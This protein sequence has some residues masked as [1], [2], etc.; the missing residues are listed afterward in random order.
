MNRRIGGNG[1]SNAFVTMERHARVDESD[2]GDLKLMSLVDNGRL[3]VSI[4]NED[5]IRGL[6][7]TKAELLVARTELLGTVGIGQEATGAPEGVG[8]GRVGPNLLGH[9][10][11]DFVVERVGV[12]EHEAATLAGEGGH[13]VAR[14]AHANEGLVGVDD[15][16]LVTEAIGVD[17]EM[18]LSNSPTQLGVRA[19]QLL[20][21]DRM[22]RHASPSIRLIPPSLSLYSICI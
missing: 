8:G 21:H 3:A 18:L 7:G 6:G 12:D 20:N 16:H 11:E 22:D 10:L 2:N 17:L 4:E 14:A 9:E 1:I 19:Q 5:A 13:E 15:H